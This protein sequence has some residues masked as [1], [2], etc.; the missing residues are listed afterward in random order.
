MVPTLNNLPQLSFCN[1]GVRACLIFFGL[2]NIF[3]VILFAWFRW[4]DLI[5]VLLL[6]FGRFH[7][8]IPCRG[9]SE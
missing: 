2:A 6:L 4:I 1:F 8:L 3:R 9:A 7:Y 5:L